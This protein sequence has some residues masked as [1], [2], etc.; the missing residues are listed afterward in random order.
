[1]SAL[2][3]AAQ[4]R[5]W[6]SMLLLDTTAAIVVQEHSMSTLRASGGGSRV[7]F[8]HRSS[9]FLSPITR[10]IRRPQYSGTEMP[11]ATSFS[12]MWPCR[13]TSECYLLL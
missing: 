13:E 6:G 5:S 8:M 1:M 3:Q 4:V 9:A 12:P 10:A 11:M 7:A 2:L